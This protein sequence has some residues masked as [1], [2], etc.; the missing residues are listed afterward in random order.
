MPKQLQPSLFP[1]RQPVVVANG[2]GVDSMALFIYMKRTGWRPDLILHADPGSE[3]PQTYDYIP[4]MN[5]ALASWGFP[6]ITVV[7]YVPS[8]FKHWPPYYTLEE[9]CFTNGTLPSLAFGFKSCSQKWKV[10]PQNKYCESWPPAIECWQQGGRVLKLIGYDAGPKDQRRC[11]HVG[12]PQDPR[13]EYRHPLTELGWDRKRCIA[14]IEKE[15]WPVPHKSSCFFCPSIQ[16]KEVEELP[17][18]LLRRIVLME[19]RAKPRLHKIE[20]LCRRKRQRDDR[21]ARLP[22]SSANNGYFPPRKSTGS[23]IKYQL[24]WF[25]ISKRTWMAQQCHRSHNSF[26]S[27]SEGI[28]MAHKPR[29]RYQRM[30]LAMALAQAIERQAT[31]DG[32]KEMAAAIQLV[33]G[34][35]A[36]LLSRERLGRIQTILHQNS[37]SCCFKQRGYKWK[38]EQGV[39]SVTACTACK[40]FTNW[41]DALQAAMSDQE[42]RE[43]KPAPA[44]RR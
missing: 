36:E 42:F 16:P 8:N 44:L 9:N 18:N 23:C 3:F 32:L 24:S 30:Q 11:N 35:P 28:R 10:A 25:A 20:G 14:E 12:D 40:K 1:V 22:N 37:G 15:G 34:A 39:W 7:R 19:A 17:A 43:L 5:R 38:F 6:T 21:L 29:S 41:A 26:R 31:E 13:Y 2:V 33:L 27:S 4:V